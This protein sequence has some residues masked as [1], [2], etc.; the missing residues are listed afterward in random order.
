MVG[1]LQAASAVIIT[2][3]AVD[4]FYSHAGV[5]C[6]EWNKPSVTGFTHLQRDPHN[7]GLDSLFPSAKYSPLAKKGDLVTIDGHS[8][9][10]YRG[11]IPSVDPALNENFVEMLEWAR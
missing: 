5:H 7:L 10:V 2:S 1:L 8:G 11:E 9:I 3:S 4:G 6:R